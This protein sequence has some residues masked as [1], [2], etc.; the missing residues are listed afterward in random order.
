MNSQT[1]DRDRSLR[2]YVSSS[3]RDMNAE[4][5][6]LV[7]HVFPQLQKFCEQRG[8]TFTGVVMQWGITQEQAE[9][10]EV[11]PICLAEIDRCRPY[12]IGLL[13]ERYGSVP[14]QIPHELLEE[15]PWLAEFR[16]RSITELEILHGA[17]NPADTAQAYFYFRDPHHSEGL[18]LD[19]RVD[20]EEQSDA[21]RLRMAGLKSSIRQSGFPLREN[22]PDAHTFG[23]FVLE[24]LVGAIDRLFPRAELPDPLDR[25]ADQHEAFARSRTRACVAQERYFPQLDAHAGKTSPPLVIIGDAG[26]GKSALLASWSRHYRDG[27]PEEFALIHF[28]DAGSDSSDWMALLRR[29]MQE[30]KRRFHIASDIPT[31]PTA[32]RGAFSNWLDMAS[33]KGRVVLVLDGL[34]R[35]S[36]RD[37]AAD[38]AWLP[39]MV[40]SN[41]R[42]ILSS[43]PGRSLD[44]LVS[45]PR[46]S[47]T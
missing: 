2:V 23:R 26:S 6:E 8:V 9:L 16:D 28:L 4:R 14:S 5:D 13:G 25:T 17:L 46:D 30:L 12:F 3:Y 1:F 21:A 43:L 31:H 36:I 27:H 45:C 18:P 44:E 29:I 22:Y 47:C 38:L 41:I 42:L 40:P 35:L 11:L 19:R 20:F 34:D 15:E 37:G 24:D 7:R 39:P 10:D 33:S 32:I